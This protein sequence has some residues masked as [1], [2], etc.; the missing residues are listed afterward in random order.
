MPGPPCGSPSSRDA[1]V[2]V[3]IDTS[4]T[5]RGPSGTGVY[6]ERLVEALTAV[7]GV[8][9]V[10]VRRRRRPRPGA[11]NPLRSAVNALLDLGWLHV[12]LPRAARATHADVVHHP[13][14][15]HSGRI[16]VP[17][18]ATVHDVAFARVGGSYDP[19]WRAL[20]TRSY[21]TA[22]RR[23]AALICVSDT[24]A[25]DVEEVLEAD[26]SRV[27]VARHGPGQVRRG[28]ERSPVPGGGHLLFVG[29]A[30]P[31]KNLAGLLAAYAAYRAEAAQPAALVLA[32]ASAAA[33]GD[34]GVRGRPRPGPGGL[35]AMLRGARALAPPSLSAGFVPE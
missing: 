34:P 3:L 1:A 17:Q 22:A 25:R 10:A 2:R 24:T 32:G 26:S 5:A 11:G 20:A 23:C 27:V 21:R 9:P 33:A 7:E 35:T 14:P 29:D 13:L 4:Y 6:V 15:A 12:G 18:V 30:E 31:R 16:R 28:A 8:E 19:L